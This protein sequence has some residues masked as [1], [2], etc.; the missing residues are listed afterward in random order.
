LGWHYPIYRGSC[1]DPGNHDELSVGLT[2]SGKNFKKP[3]D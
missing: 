2:I 3:S 1:N